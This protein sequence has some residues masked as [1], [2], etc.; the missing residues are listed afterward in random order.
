MPEASLPG[1]LL[2]TVTKV[3]RVGGIN[4]FTRRRSFRLPGTRLRNMT[5]GKHVGL[6]LGDTFCSLFIGMNKLH[7]HELSA[8][9]S[10]HPITGNDLLRLGRSPLGEI[11]CKIMLER[12]GSGIAARPSQ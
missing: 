2:H 7:P 3:N 5:V 1:Q 12:L 6:I 11:A 4:V 10:M 8:Q 9:R